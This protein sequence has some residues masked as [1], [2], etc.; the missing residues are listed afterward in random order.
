MRVARLLELL[1]L[2]QARRAATADELAEVL[3]VSRRTVYRDVAALAAAGVPVYTEQGRHG[4]VRLLETFDGEWSG[5][6][7][8]EEAR[9]LVLAGVPAVAT[10]VGLD[11]D[12]AQAKLVGALTGAARRAVHDVR[13]RILVETEPWWGRQ[14]GEPCLPQLARAVWASREVR[15]EYERSQDRGP[16]V[17][18]PLGLVLKGNVWYVV[19]DDRR[20]AR[21]V[22]RV[23]R[24]S[25]AEVLPHQFDRPD[26]FDL[27]AAWAERKVGFVAAIPR[28]AVEVRVSPSATGLLALLQE[29]TPPLPLADDLPLDGDGW[30]R[31][32]LTFERPDSAARLLLQLGGD[33]EVLAPAELRQLMADA[34]RALSARYCDEP[35]RTA[36]ASR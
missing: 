1:L 30:T 3:E 22:Y 20:R 35:E 19:A 14:P 11:P 2:L 31:L 26:H 13:D 4:G 27:A 34:A 29:G 23:S 10:S 9:A 36:P 24:V 12:S 6:L 18:R 33:V 32:S 21:R 5:A 8:G 15:I 7:G 28:Y 25:D 17:I 16:R